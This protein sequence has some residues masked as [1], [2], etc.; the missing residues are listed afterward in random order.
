MDT[1]KRSPGT[2]AFCGR[3]NVIRVVVKAD[4]VVV[5]VVVVVDVVGLGV[6]IGAGHVV[7]DWDACTHR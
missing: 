1:A 2:Q 3:L 6:G 4:E 7:D 5:I